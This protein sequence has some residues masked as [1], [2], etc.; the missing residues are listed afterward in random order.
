[1][2]PVSILSDSW[3]V[4]AGCEMSTRFQIKM[5]VSDMNKKE[6]TTQQTCKCSAAACLLSPGG[7]GMCKTRKLPEN[8]QT[9][10]NYHTKGC[11]SPSLP[12][13]LRGLIRSCFVLAKSRLIIL[14]HKHTAWSLFLRSS[15][16]ASSHLPWP[17]SQV[18]LLNPGW[19]ECHQKMRE[20]EGGTRQWREDTRLLVVWVRVKRKKVGDSMS[21]W[22]F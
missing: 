1:M 14:P 2:L 11:A 16:R 3:E 7:D 8:Q 6:I 4:L 21:G 17:L 15:R 12:G 9:C 18:C 10:H 22:R 20:H 13:V 5:L 19:Q